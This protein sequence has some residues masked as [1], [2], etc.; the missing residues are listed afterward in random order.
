MLVIGRTNALALSRA[1]EQ[2]QPLSAGMR[3]MLLL[4]AMVCA[5]AQAQ[6]RA[7]HAIEPE[8]AYPLHH[9]LLR[10]GAAAAIVGAPAPAVSAVAGTAR[11]DACRQ[12]CPAAYAPVCGAGGTYLNA[13]WAA[14]QGAEPFAV[15]DCDATA[16]KYQRSMGSGCEARCAAVGPAGPAAAV[17]AENGFTYTSSCVAKCSNLATVAGTCCAL[18]SLLLRSATFAFSSRHALNCTGLRT[19]S[20]TLLAAPPVTKNG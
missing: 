19:T 16:D 2:T 3:P 17:C 15:G 10:D 13:C 18:L 1:A 20:G 9:R 11:I 7:A 8:R 12:R 14:C 6:A 4:A 5:A